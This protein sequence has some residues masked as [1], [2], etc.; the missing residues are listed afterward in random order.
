MADTIS[1]SRDKRRRKSDVSL[2]A[3]NKVPAT[4]ILKFGKYVAVK[5]KTATLDLGQRP[6][7]IGYPCPRC[8]WVT[9]RPARVGSQAPVSLPDLN[10]QP[11]HLAQKSLAALKPRSGGQDPPFSFLGTALPCDKEVAVSVPANPLVTNDRW[12]FQS[13]FISTWRSMRKE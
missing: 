11:L 8:V 7:T 1:L 12:K 6:L 5:H 10:G 2:P 13:S 3:G 9:S 4:G